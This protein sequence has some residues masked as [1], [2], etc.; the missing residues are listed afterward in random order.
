MRGLEGKLD[1]INKIHHLRRY[2][3]VVL[4]PSYI[5]NVLFCTASAHI[6]GEKEMSGLMAQ[7]EPPPVF[8]EAEE[9]RLVIPYSFS[10]GSRYG[11]KTF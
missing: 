11:D 8:P 1:S 6:E 10:V 2:S 7:I 3:N 5:R 9:S 4:K